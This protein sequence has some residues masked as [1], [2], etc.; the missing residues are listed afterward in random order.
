MLKILVQK[1]NQNKELL[2]KEIASK[3]EFM[4]K[5]T[6]K[7]L[8]KLTFDTIFNSGEDDGYFTSLNTNEITEID[9]GDYQGT[10]LY[11][12]PFDMYQPGA[13]DY[14]LTHV[15]YGSCSVC[16][17]LRSIQYGCGDEGLTE[18]RIINFMNLCQNIVVNT[19]KPYNYGWRYDKN[20]DVVEDII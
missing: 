10:L 20:F 2:R 18:S 12:I 3:P 1:W 7:D 4:K 6:Y 14:L 16:D 5:C 19:V 15:S 8:V 13:C 9:D 17:T 11:M